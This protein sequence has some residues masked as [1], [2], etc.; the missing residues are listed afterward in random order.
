MLIQITG[1]NILLDPVWSKRAM[2]KMVTSLRDWL[3]R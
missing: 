1:V 3:L 2:A